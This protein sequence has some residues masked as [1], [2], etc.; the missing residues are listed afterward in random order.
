M[1]K[2]KKKKENLKKLQ[3]H[4]TLL[5]NVADPAPA[6]ASTTSVPAFWIRSVMAAA[7]ASEK[8]T[9]GVACESKGRMVVPAW[10]PTTG[11]STS[12]TSRPLASY[13]WGR[14]LGGL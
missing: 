1:K 3:L 10:P 6:L 11:T 9:F 2:K 5:T 4:S 14:S 13:R 8:E 12:A 7:S